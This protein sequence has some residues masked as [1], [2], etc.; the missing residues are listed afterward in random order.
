MDSRIPH[1]EWS[2]WLKHNN[3]TSFDTSSIDR[4]EKD[5]LN[6][7]YSQT[8]GLGPLNSSE[9]KEHN[10]AP[11]HPNNNQMDLPSNP[12][13]KEIETIPTS[14]GSNTSED[15]NIHD[16]LYKRKRLLTI[17]NLKI[18]SKTTSKIKTTAISEN[19]KIMKALGYELYEMEQKEK[20]LKKSIYQRI[21]IEQ[22]RLPLKFLF[23]LPNG[24]Y[25]CRTRI[26]NAMKLWIHEFELNQLAR[27]WLQW[28]GFIEMLRYRERSGEY[29]IQAGK[30]HGIDF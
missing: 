22:N 10:K 3:N 13:S 2:Y 27:A 30:F 15:L 21:S 19:H 14:A 1:I 17:L 7:K 4:E 12:L 5:E 29:Y 24:V 28:K 11:I 6:L 20:K 26:H 25:F 16:P 18:S 8:I 23:E 9:E